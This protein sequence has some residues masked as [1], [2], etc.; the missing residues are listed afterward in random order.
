M[1]PE[2]S[3]LILVYVFLRVVYDLYSAGSKSVK[4]IYVKDIGSILSVFIIFGLMFMLIEGGVWAS[5]VLLS[6]SVNINPNYLVLPTYAVGYELSRLY[7]IQRYPDLSRNKKLDLFF[8]YFI[9]S[10]CGVLFLI[11]VVFITLIIQK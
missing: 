1:T 5:K 7:F 9:C 6:D 8:R 3:V 10:S 2:P 4:R 11:S